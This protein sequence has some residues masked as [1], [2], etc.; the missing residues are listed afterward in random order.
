MQVQDEVD[1]PLLDVVLKAAYV[2][3]RGASSEAVASEIEVKCFARLRVDLLRL[4][5]RYH[6]NMF[7]GIPWTGPDVHNCSLHRLAGGGA[8]MSDT[9]NAARKT[10]RLLTEMIQKEAEAKLSDAHGT[11]VWDALPEE[12][13]SELLRV[14][15]LDCQHHLRNIWLGHM[16][17]RQAAHV[18][19]A[20]ADH[21]NQFSAWERMTTDYDQLL[22]AVYK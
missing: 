8:L 1:A 4:C 15:K 2:S 19:A 13:R 17:Q 10:K 9:C 21:L 12:R 18:Q 3:T 6:D 14:H 11:E 16:S 7:P 22:R 20:L 5:K